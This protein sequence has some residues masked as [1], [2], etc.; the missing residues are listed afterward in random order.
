MLCVTKDILRQLNAAVGKLDVDTGEVVKG[1]IGRLEMSDGLYHGVV[2][3]ET[4]GENPPQDTVSITSIIGQDS[5][6]NE[7]GGVDDG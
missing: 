7:M 3:Y 4:A 6:L 5:S 1:F 2:W